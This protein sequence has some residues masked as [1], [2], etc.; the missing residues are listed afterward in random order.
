MVA[1]HWWGVNVTLEPLVPLGMHPLGTGLSKKF[2][3]YPCLQGRETVSLTSLEISYVLANLSIQ[4][5]GFLNCALEMGALRL[6]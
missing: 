3:S 1:V 5:M 2:S 6:V 4:I